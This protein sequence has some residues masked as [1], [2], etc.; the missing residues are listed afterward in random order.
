MPKSS[1]G[2][3]LLP[4][5]LS[6]Q[7]TINFSNGTI[8]LAMDPT[9][10]ISVATVTP[11]VPAFHQDQKVILWKNIGPALSQKWLAN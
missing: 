4:P 9:T 5:S 1:L 6:Q 3:G 10:V 2:G 11:Y 8:H 7:W